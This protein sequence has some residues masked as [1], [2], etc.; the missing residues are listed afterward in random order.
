MHLGKHTNAEDYFI[1]G[2]KIDGTEC[3][4]DLGVLV[5]YDGKW[6]E[7][8]NSAASKTVRVLGKMKN[9]LSS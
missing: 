7:Q 9:T 1:A 2:K 3:E 8:V 4:R 5:L 6:H